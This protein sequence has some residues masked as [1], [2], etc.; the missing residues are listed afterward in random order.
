MQKRKLEIPRE[1]ELVD[2]IDDILRDILSLLG[3]ELS[4]ET[5]NLLSDAE[6]VLETDFVNGKT[7][8]EKDLKKIKNEYDFDDIKGDLDEGYIPPVLEFFYG[9]DNEN[10]RINCEMLGLNGDNSELIA[11]ICSEKGEETMQY[12]SL[13]IHVET[14][15]AFYDN[16]NTN[17]SFNEFLLV[18]QDENKQIIKKK[19][20][21]L[22]DF[23]HYWDCFLQ[24]FDFEEVDKYNL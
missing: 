2:K 12:N 7:L 23:K 17:E 9:S 15:N 8:N 20:L 24:S 5:L 1:Q 6:G 22:H 10:F 16:F 4:D 19:I 3:L 11:F 18:Q 13:S 14:G 21:Y